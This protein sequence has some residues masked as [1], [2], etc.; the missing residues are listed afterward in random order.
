[1]RRTRHN[2]VPY[3]KRGFTLLATVLLITL[4]IAT[5]SELATL[6]ATDALV[7][8]RRS[9]TLTHRLAV[10]SAMR[11]LADL[12]SNETNLDGIN[13]EMARLGESY[14]SFAVGDAIVECRLRDDSARFNPRF[15]QKDSDQ[16][17]LSRK[18]NLLLTDHGLG[19]RVTL[20]P[21]AKKQDSEKT[22]TR[23]VWYDQLLSCVQ[24]G[25]FFLWDVPTGG[26]SNKVVWSD[27]VTLW[28][29]G[30]VNTSR[31]SEAVLHA[32]LDDIRPD[33]ARLIVKARRK[34]STDDPALSALRDVPAELR[35]RVHERVTVDAVRFAIRLDTRVGHDHRRWYVVAEIK[36]GDMEVLHRSQLTW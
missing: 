22:E 35:G 3:R 25:D 36:T 29:D 34:N 24:P 32:A 12:L 27:V 5:V 4:L 28:G 8:S 30:R 10:D 18:L 26:P 1:M 6:T 16:T 23:Y 31:A 9:R 17:L 21:L 7:A 2:F 11:Y 14:R 19:G 13:E 20:Q 15:F 33:L